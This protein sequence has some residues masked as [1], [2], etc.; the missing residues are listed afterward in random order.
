GKKEYYDSNQDKTKLPYVLLVNEGTAST[1]E[2]IAAA[3]KDTGDGILAGTKTFG[4][5][6]IQNTRQ[7]SEG[8]AFKLTTYQYF[9]PKGKTIHKKGVKPEYF[10]KDNDSEETDIQLDKALDLLR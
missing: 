6:I 9:S 5:G 4:K 1:S 10:I 2:I 3:V 8:D 7:L